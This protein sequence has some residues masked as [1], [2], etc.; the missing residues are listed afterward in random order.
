MHDAQHS[1]LSRERL[2]DINSEVLLYPVVPVVWRRRVL[3]VEWT[4]IEG[5]SEVRGGVIASAIWV[6][7]CD[8]YDEV[9][10]ARACGARLQSP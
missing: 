5:G 1:L 2:G 6:A 10:F 7:R 8:G 3:R 9:E 4:D